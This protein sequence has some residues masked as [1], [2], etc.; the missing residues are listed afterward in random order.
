MKKPHVRTN[1]DFEVT[2]PVIK[3]IFWVV[4]FLVLMFFVIYPLTVFKG[5]ISPVRTQTAVQQTVYDT[6]D[7]DAFAVRSE[8]CINNTYSGTIVPAVTNGNKVAMGDTV[9][10]IY[11]NEAAA[12]NASRLK[13]LQN[14]IEYYRSIESAVGGT[15]QTD[16]DLYKSSVT[17]S[18]FSL[19]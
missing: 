2:S 19:S 6:I 8:V 15:L 10:D 4:L 7:V 3:N 11:A 9:A 17:K 18:L 16:I 13:E 12:Q 5:N 1:I 14:E